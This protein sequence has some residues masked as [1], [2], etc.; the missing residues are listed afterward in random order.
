MQKLGNN[1][2]YGRRLWEVIQG[3]CRIDF[4]LKIERTENLLITSGNLTLL[5]IYYFNSSNLGK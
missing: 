5:N 4:L 3:S 1:C 2:H